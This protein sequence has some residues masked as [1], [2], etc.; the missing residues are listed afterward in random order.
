MDRLRQA[1][2]NRAIAAQSLPDPAARPVRLGLGRQQGAGGDE[3]N[4]RFEGRCT[5]RGEVAMTTVT[6]ERPIETARGIPRQPLRG[7]RAEGEPGIGIGLTDD[8][9]QCAD[10]DKLE[11][12]QAD[13][14]ILAEASQ[15][16]L[17]KRLRQFVLRQS[18]RIEAQ[19]H[20][21][22]DVFAIP[23]LTHGIGRKAF[24]FAGGA[25]EAVQAV[26]RLRP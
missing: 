20:L 11:L 16:K 3:Q 13:A 4:R 24:S 26:A 9:G 5:A 1:R 25:G 19:M 10:P 17:G 14:G 22:L 6:G 15:A 21:E 23:V 7:A 2:R 18:A 8:Q 12:A